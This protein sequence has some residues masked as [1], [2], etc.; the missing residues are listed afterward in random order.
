MP[1]A[2]RLRP[3]LRA[4]LLAALLMAGADTA[5]AQAGASA[6]FAGAW[7]ETSAEYQA[8]LRTLETRSQEETAAAVHRLR[9]S[10]QQMAERFA[11]NRPP[12]LTG[13]PEWPA[14]FIQIDLRLVGALLVTPRGGRSRHWRRRWRGCARRSRPHSDGRLA[15]VPLHQF[16]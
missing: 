14:E 5:A 8:A 16:T 15:I 10:F 9:Q 11:A 12:H 13:D 4:M 3:G 2:R 6:T 7:E 1:I